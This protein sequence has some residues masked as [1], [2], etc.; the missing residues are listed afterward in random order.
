MG[1]S[2]EMSE[3]CFVLPTIVPPASHNTRKAAEFCKAGGNS[4]KKALLPTDVRTPHISKQSLTAIRQQ[5]NGSCL[6]ERCGRHSG[7]ATS[8]PHS[9][10][11]I[12][13]FKAYIFCIC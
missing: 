7:T 4:S 10:D 1:S 2:L 12:L 5:R 11:D 6:V 8:S 9:V 13:L 3:Q